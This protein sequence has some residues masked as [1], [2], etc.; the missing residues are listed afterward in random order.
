MTP[1]ELFRTPATELTAAI[2]AKQLSPV[3]LTEALLARIEAV[4]PA[5]NAYLDVAGDRAL[6]AARAAEAAVMPRR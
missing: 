3:E 5:I 2:R 6:D 1:P 4:N